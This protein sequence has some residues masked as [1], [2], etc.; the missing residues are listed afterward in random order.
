LR[1]VVVVDKTAPSAPMVNE[2]TSLATLVTGET[3][4]GAYIT[5]II[6]TETYSSRAFSNGTFR[7]IIPQQKVG[8]LINVRSTDAAGNK[9]P[10]SKELVVE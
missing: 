1:K 5:V 10:F 6:G 8:T 4:G 7:V 3:E 9:S 2:I